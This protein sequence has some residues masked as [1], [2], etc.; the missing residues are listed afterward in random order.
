MLS[1]KEGTEASRSGSFKIGQE[2]GKKH[3][4]ATAEKISPG[5]DWYIS[6]WTTNAKVRIQENCGL[7]AVSEGA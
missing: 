5:G 2:W 1:S 3:T 6:L 4:M 7:H